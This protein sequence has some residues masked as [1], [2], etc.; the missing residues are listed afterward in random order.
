MKTADENKTTQN[1]IQQ[2][3]VSATPSCSSKVVIVSNIPYHGDL[4]SHKK[5]QNK[6]SKDLNKHI[7][8]VNK[9]L[10]MKGENYLGYRRD[11]KAKINKT[12]KVKQDR[13]HLYVLQE[14]HTQV[15]DNIN[16]QQRRY[17]F[18]NFWKNMNWEQ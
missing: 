15:M 11:R 7:R 16:E 4:L 14:I 10:R 6:A 5:R 3:C 12:F 2:S 13:V 9:E 18:E 1:N 8:N 17:L